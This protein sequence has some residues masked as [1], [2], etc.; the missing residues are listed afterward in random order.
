[1]SIRFMLGA[2]AHTARTTRDEEFENLYKTQVKPF[3]VTLYKYPKIQA[4]LHYSGILLQRIEKAHPEFF[5]LLEDLVARKQ[6]ELLGGGFY[7][8]IL[9][10]LPLQDKIGQIELLTTYIRRQFGKRPQGCVLPA[11]AWEQNLVAP[12]TTCGMAYTFLDEQWFPSPTI[13][14][15][16][17]DQGKIITMFPVSYTL[18]RAF[19]H[20]NPR[21]VLE[22]LLVTI[23]S[24]QDTHVITVFPECFY[25]EGDDAAPEFALHAFF[26]ALSGFDTHFEFTMPGKIFK[27]LHTLPKV[28]FP[29]STTQSGGVPRQCLIDY[30]EANG[31]Y[32]KMMF[33]HILINQLRGDKERKH[34]AR[35]ELWKAQACDA[36][37]PTENGGIYRSAA[38]KAAYKALLSAEKITREN[39]FTPSLIS[40]DFDLD[41]E[42]EALFQGEELN[43]YIQVTGASVFELDYLPRCWNYLDTFSPERALTRRNA[44]VDRLASSEARFAI[45]ADS[46]FCSNER[47]ELVEL[48]KDRGFAR[49][50]LPPLHDVLPFGNIALDK[51][52]HL[53]KNT[54]CLRYI[55]SNQGT[56]PA[57]F[58]LVPVIDLS[59]PGD[60]ETMLRLSRYS[61]ESE[62]SI[63]P[64]NAVLTDT[65]GLYFQDIRNEVNLNLLFDR[66]VDIEIKSITSPVGALPHTSKPMAFPLSPLRGS[67]TQRL[68]ADVYQSTCISPLI[69][70][71]FAAGERFETEIHLQIG[72]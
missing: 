20:Q 58:N 1:M 61:S 44:F 40:F 48:N 17:E 16:T 43:C 62:E 51:M 31:I 8:P 14:C 35:E 66:R 71:S 27:N 38:R 25:A 11:Q 32:A 34:S 60:G 2:H 12:L 21:K 46:R 57:C 59:F 4:S 18:R 5:M 10:L 19:T 49:F 33:T 13:P 23:T 9:P 41:G 28:Y 24:D 68:A 54:L 50:C 70:V 29:G 56:E 42:R 52:Y 26:E 39:G 47:F 30:P 69:P 64:D 67:A 37:Y 3:V 45:S 65:D 36:F 15:L 6:I 53:Q 7:E 22:N 63:S 72:P 55:L